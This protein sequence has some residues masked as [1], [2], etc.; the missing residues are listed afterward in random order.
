MRAAD[1]PTDPQPCSPAERA[2]YA[3]KDD[4]P[5]AAGDDDASTNGTDAGGEPDRDRDPHAALR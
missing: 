1:I 3:A 5:E 4:A 2:S